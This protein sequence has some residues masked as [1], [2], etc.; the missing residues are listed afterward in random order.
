ME[1]GYLHVFVLSRIVRYRH[2]RT[3]GKPCGFLHTDIC[4]A[5]VFRFALECGYVVENVTGET[6]VSTR[7]RRRHS[8]STRL[9]FSRATPAIAASSPTIAPGPKMATIRSSRHHHLEQPL[10]EA[11]APVAGIPRGEEYA[12]GLNLAQPRDIE[13]LDSCR[14]AGSQRIDH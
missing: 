5:G 11:I 3:W 6:P 10:V 12:A 8:P 7:L 9:A 4:L 14:R 2:L 13:Q 1:F